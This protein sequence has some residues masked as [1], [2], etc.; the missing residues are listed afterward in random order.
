MSRR[1]FK[2]AF[3]DL[4]NNKRKSAVALCAI[5]IGMIAFGT[6]LFSHEIII[7]EI[8]T[9]YSSINP[10]SASVSVACVDSR[11]I[12]LTE[13]FYGIEEYVVKAQYQMRGQK[14][15]GEW[16]T[17]ELFA[18]DN[19]VSMDINK[20]FYMDG[21]E[22]PEQD[23]MLIERDAI[24]VAGKN[25]GDM[26]LL[27]LPNGEEKQL[28]ITGVINDLSVHPAIMHNT[29]YV[30]VS[31]E[32][33]ELMGLSPNRI[34]FKIIGD[35]Y[36]R[37]S[38][39][40]IS[41]EYM[42]M[43]EQ[44]GYQI[45]GLSV[46]NTPGVSMHLNEYKTV[47]FLLRTF[48]FAAF[49]FGCLIMSSLINSIIMEQLR[50]IGILKTFGTKTSIITMSY[51]LAMLLFVG[52][53][54]IISLLI[55]KKLANSLSQI[56]LRVSN[57]NLSHIYVDSAF[58]AIFLLLCVTVPLV[59]SFL[60]VQR[61]A[62][63]TVKDAIDDSGLSSVRITKKN[64]FRQHIGT[65][66]WLPRPIAITM[67]NALRKKGRFILNVATLALS[68]MCFISVLVSM[69][70]VSS[71]L[72]DN[73]NTF[74]YDYHFVT[75]GVD[76]TS[77]SELFDENTEIDMYEYWGYTSGEL[78]YENGQIG[79]SYQIFAIPDNSKLVT[80]DVLEGSWIQETAIEEIVV[81]HEFLQDNPEVSVGS[82]I[83]LAVRETQLSVQ[84]I[85]QIKDFSG[86]NIYMCKELYIQNIPDESRQDIVQVK[87]DSNR[88]G[89]SKEK[90][91]QEIEEAILEQGISIL[92]SETKENA[93]EVLN[94]HYEATFQAFLVVIFMVL[95]VAAFGLSSTT[96][97]QTLERKRE[98]GIMKAMGA[99]KKQIVRIITSESVFTGLCGWVL[100][101]VL[102]IGGIIL[103][104]IYFGRITLETS[105]DLNVG[106]VFAGY[107]IWLFMVL[108]VGR[109]AS[110]HSAIYAANMTVK[111]SLG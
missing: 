15:D 70:S 73:L 35:S 40:K 96:N 34:D 97:I 20:V 39:L 8:V 99:D 81:G 50:Q 30:Y 25:M 68:G 98:I 9:T 64:L 42:H 51:L 78:V 11:L 17:V 33:L 29:I 77:L 31:M 19:Y 86:P 93:I 46:E 111:E 67:R 82:I 101:A 87:L 104:I 61:G 12:Q 91:I 45:N 10:P 80:P 13:E 6:L 54:S 24:N 18:C 107:I 23:E 60:A 109:M 105:I 36:D 75:N 110:R 95:L 71:T 63:I 27:S 94:R 85:G 56:M 59:I 28:T 79:N 22:N 102:A 106:A 66:L 65:I 4:F 7:N 16:S 74:G 1:L 57:M 76:D 47:L 3:R 90:L 58:Y 44:N 108:F 84:I 21:K 41:N 49:L 37:E 43:L 92:Q 48:A 26:L 52:V 55:S 32:T 103:G 69:I 89:R 2:K 88:R 100:S 72:K 83:T 53:A 5:V 38:I 62:K 14:E